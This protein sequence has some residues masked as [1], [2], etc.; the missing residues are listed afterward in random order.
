MN[1][2]HISTIFGDPDLKPTREQVIFLGRFLQDV[3]SSKLKRDFPDRDI[4]VNFYEEG[5]E[6]LLDYQITFYSES[7]SQ[8][9]STRPLTVFANANPVRE[10]FSKD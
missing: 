9:G 7:E 4:Q 2:V 5:C 8:R 1:H 10:T 3:W 6:E